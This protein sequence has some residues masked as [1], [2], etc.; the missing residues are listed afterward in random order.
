MSHFVR[1]GPFD[2]KPLPHVTEGDVCPRCDYDAHDG[3][4]D[5]HEDHEPSDDELSDFY[6]GGGTRPI[7]EQYREA[8]EQKRRMR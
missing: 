8:A 1:T 4:C 6:G 7:E 5:P 2:P 3:P